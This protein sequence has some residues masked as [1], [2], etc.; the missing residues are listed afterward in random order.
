MN[1]AEF[2]VNEIDNY[3]SEIEGK[4][5]YLSKAFKDSESFE[6]YYIEAEYMVER[7]YSLFSD[8][9][10]AF[11]FS[12]VRAMRYAY[13]VTV[14]SDASDLVMPAGNASSMLRSMQGT[15]RSFNKKARLNLV[16]V[17][18][19]SAI[20][21]F[22]YPEQ[23]YRDSEFDRPALETGFRTMHSILTDEAADQGKKT[24]ELLQLFSGDTKK[25]RSAMNLFK[26]LTPV[27]GSDTSVYVLTE[28]SENK[29]LTINSEVRAT[30]NSIV[31]PTQTKDVRVDW[32]NQIATGYIR[33]INN[34]SKS[35]ILF[36]E[37]KEDKEDSALIKIHY[38]N[39][40]SLEKEVLAAFKKKAQ[41]NFSKEPGRQKY[42]VEKLQLA[43]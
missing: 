30:I 26:G 38:G 22:D 32:D 25:H 34:V 2:Q 17:L 41:V 43:R 13:S 23:L 1:D 14:K 7:L 33:E 10:E 12:R 37:R 40:E 42:N 29:G 11:M 36:A 19:G 24:K 27:P 18:H 15:L 5:R 9:E 8:L 3:L 6:D 21:C 16:N 20:F 28:F 31:P 35:F 39:S 4:V